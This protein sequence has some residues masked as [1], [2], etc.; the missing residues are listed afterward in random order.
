[1][2]NVFEYSMVDTSATLTVTS[3]ADITSAQC[4]AVKLSGGKAV[5]P[6]VGEIPAGILLISSE[7]TIKNGEEATIQIK[8]MGTWKAG[9][10]FAAGDM[11]AAD[12]EGL[13][14]KATE[15]QFMY[16]RA[17][18]AATAKGDL[19]KVQIVNAGYVA[20]A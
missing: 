19:V 1:M 5:L 17:L 14:Q 15:G 18:E 12:A 8:D 3:G 20:R 11:L 6:S 16:A 4:K 9:T 7:D 2:A 10:A 13:C